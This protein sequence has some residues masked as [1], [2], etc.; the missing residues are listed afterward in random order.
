MI[1]KNEEDCIATC[2]NSIKGICDE[3]VI[4]DTGC[5]D[6]T[7]EVVAEINKDYGK[8]KTYT[9]QWRDD[10][11]HARNFAMSNFTTDYC[12]TTDADE[13]FSEGLQEEIKKLKED[14]FK[15]YN[16]IELYLINYDRLRGNSY[17]LGGRTIT[18]KAE[19]VFW[20]YSI[21]EKL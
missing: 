11:S 4:V 14:D 10:F 2:L 1:V 17:Y 20:R 8:I 13:E 6:R 19:S 7:M 16:A 12:F 9:Y 15:N 18:R 3:I 21:H 5:N